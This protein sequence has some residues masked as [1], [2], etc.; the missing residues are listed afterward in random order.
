MIMPMRVSLIE[1]LRM[2]SKVISELEAR[3]SPA[4]IRAAKKDPHSRREP[5]PCGLTVHTGRGCPFGCVYC[6]VPDMGIPMRPRPNVLSGLQIAYAIAIN[7]YIVVGKWGTYLAFGSITEPLLPGIR[8]KTVEYL[9]AIRDHLGN[10]TQ[11]STKEKVDERLAYLV[12]SADNKLSVLVS[13]T[14]LRKKLE[15]GAPSIEERINTMKNFKKMGMH[16]TL[17]MRPIIPGISEED[18][19][20]ILEMA[21]GIVDAVI[22]GGF[23]VTPSIIKRLSSV[24]VPPEEIESRLIREPKQR[25]QVPVKVDDIKRLLIKLANRMGYRVLPS[26]CAANAV[27]H[28][29][30]CHMCNM[31]PCFSMDLPDFE[32]DEVPILANALGFNVKKL[33][34]EGYKLK[35]IGRGSKK[36]VKKLKHVLSVLT[37][38]IVSVKAS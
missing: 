35:V 36:S 27:A 13:A 2:K 32:L 1:H 29:I 38:R 4:E 9:R 3:L 30:P 33:V 26:A 16:V 24:G 17:F 28:G 12:W 22:I 8:E 31:G 18:G 19:P 11:I 5:R 6:Y 23:R 14:T 15:P 37:K 10:P 25:E 7:P 20:K 21:S 34:L